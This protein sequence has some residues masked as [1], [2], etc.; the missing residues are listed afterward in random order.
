MKQYYKF[1]LPI[2]CVFIL[3]VSCKKA[4]YLTDSGVH[5]AKTPLSTY[6]YMKQHPWKLFDTLITIIDQYNLRDEV[7][8]ANTFFAPTDYAIKSYMDARLAE[9][10]ATNAA[11]EYTMD[12]L[13]KYI[14]ADS[15]RQYMFSEKI[16]LQ[17]LPENETRAFA[18]LGKTSMGAY[19]ELQTANDYTQ[20]TNAP[21]YFLYLVK[22]RG[23]L[24][25]PGSVPPQNEEDIKVRCQTTG[26]QT[27]N[28]AKT[29]HVLNNQ[30]TFVRF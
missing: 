27:S 21:T 9:R 28:G 15:V 18:S 19:K 1:I 7:N 11:A 24:D 22:I 23:E 30:H 4:D 13:Y 17:D 2:L 10:Q 3:A 20:Y 14:T 26:I 16:V 25:I 6:D 8:N 29:L 5:D 12:S